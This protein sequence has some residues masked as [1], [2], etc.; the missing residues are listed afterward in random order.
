M[1][2]GDEKGELKIDTPGTARTKPQKV[3]ISQDSQQKKQDLLNQLKETKLEDWTYG[4]L[5]DTV[6]DLKA[7]EGWEKLFEND[8]ELKLEKGDDRNKE[9]NKKKETALR[10][11]LFALQ[12]EM[13]KEQQRK[14]T[15]DS[16]YD[17][18]LVEILDSPTQHKIL[19]KTEGTAEKRKEIEQLTNKEDLKTI[20]LSFEKNI[21]PKNQKEAITLLNYTQND[22]KT[23]PHLSIGKHASQKQV[24]EAMRQYVQSYGYQHVALDNLS[25]AQT[26]AAVEQLIQEGASFTIN[27][28]KPSPSIKNSFYDFDVFSHNLKLAMGKHKIGNEYYEKLK[29]NMA[30]KVQEHYTKCGEFKNEQFAML[31]HV[32]N[33]QNENRYKAKATEYLSKTFSDLKHDDAILDNRKK[34]AHEWGRKLQHLYAQKMSNQQGGELLKQIYQNNIKNKNQLYTETKDYNEERKNIAQNYNGDYKE[35]FNSFSR[36]RELLAKTKPGDKDYQ[37]AKTAYEY[38]AITM[39][40]KCADNAGFQEPNDY[41][42]DRKNKEIEDLSREDQQFLEFYEMYEK[43]MQYLDGLENLQQAGLTFNQQHRQGAERGNRWDICNRLAQETMDNEDKNSYAQEIE[44]MFS[45]EERPQNL[46]QQQS[47]AQLKTGE[48]EQTNEQT[49]KL[50]H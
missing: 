11:M 40:K 43:D 7:Q 17:E 24:R 48:H 32:G 10:N 31:C 21:T 5:R 39:T 3:D 44:R 38:S 14:L 26:E 15:Y 42:Q 4:T 33:R 34:P 37:Q 35:T 19:K 18:C 8:D 47:S 12:Q 13:S 50:T 25:E 28:Y 29:D 49:N 23:T 27:S 45:P 46:H 36:A 2:N 16:K 1:A 20:N 30:N 6:Y 9:E 41:I 22:K